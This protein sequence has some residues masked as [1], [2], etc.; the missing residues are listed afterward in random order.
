MK[1][2]PD[3]TCVTSFFVTSK[4]DAAAVAPA[5]IWGE[6]G[7]AGY[8]PESI[9]IST[10]TACVFFALSLH[11]SKMETNVYCLPAMIA[12]GSGCVRAACAPASH[13][14]DGR[15]GLTPSIAS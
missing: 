5:P 10:S 3:N 13:G 7:S 4:Q 11:V 14:E 15:E 9:C 12:P 2:S 1:L 6:A 8:L